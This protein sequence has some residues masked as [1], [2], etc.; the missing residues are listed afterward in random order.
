MSTRRAHII[1]PADL[2]GQIDEL[3]GSRGRSQF[4]A[5]TARAEVHRRRL[6]QL[7]ERK[8]PGWKVEKHPELKKGAARWVDLMRQEDEKIDSEKGSR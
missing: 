5:E 7:L 6:L 2:L 1:L 8:G 4:I 3:V